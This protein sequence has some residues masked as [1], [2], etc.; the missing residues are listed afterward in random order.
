MK[1]Q[2]FDHLQSF[3]N[4][5]FTYRAI[6]AKVVKLLPQ[7]LL[8]TNTMPFRPPSLIVIISIIPQNKKSINPQ[9][10]LFEKQ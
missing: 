1:K 5:L 8:P 4:K 10:L 7:L 6:T 2:L 9:P 3:L